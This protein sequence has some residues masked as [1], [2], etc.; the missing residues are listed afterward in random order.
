MPTRSTAARTYLHDEAVAIDVTAGRATAVRTASGERIAAD[1]VIIAAGPA[2][3][4]V[5]ALVG[6]AL[7]I[8]PRKRTVFMIRAPL[9]GSDMP[10]VFDTSG[11]WIRPEGDGFICGISPPADLT[12]TPTATSIPTC[13]CWKIHSG[14]CW[15]IASRRLSNCVC[16]VPGPATTTCACSTITR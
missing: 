2:S 12:T 15:R 6:I 3:G 8:E 14:R 13:I 10:L 7:P 5:A 16:S 1:H 9:D 4:R 11:M